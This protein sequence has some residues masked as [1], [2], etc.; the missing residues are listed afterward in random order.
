M[1]KACHQHTS[2]AEKIIRDPAFGGGGAPPNPLPGN[3]A[4]GAWSESYYV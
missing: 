1:A 2:F 4:Y 3:F